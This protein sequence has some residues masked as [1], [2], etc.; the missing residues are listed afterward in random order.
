VILK[1][2]RESCL[3]PI[4]GIGNSTRLS[5]KKEYHFYAFGRSGTAGAF[6]NLLQYTP[7]EYIKPQTCNNTHGVAPKETEMCFSAANE[8]GVCGGTH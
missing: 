7:M 3:R 1:L 4:E 5:S 2:E 8:I 6:T